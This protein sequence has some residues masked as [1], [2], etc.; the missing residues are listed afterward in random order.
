MI[1]MEMLTEYIVDKA[2]IVIPV[3]LILGKIFKETPKIKRWLIPYMLLVIGIAFSIGLIGFSVN[4][5][6]Q[7]VLVSGAAVFG[8]QLY[9]QVRN[10][11]Q[12]E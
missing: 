8:H 6:I 5:I 2:L 7:G 1:N 3:L 11:E 4:A 9:R 10:R 12:D